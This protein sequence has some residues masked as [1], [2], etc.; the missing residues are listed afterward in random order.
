M[1]VDGKTKADSSEPPK[2]SPVVLLLGTLGDTTWRMFVP[3]V[4]LMSAGYYADK[5]FATFPWL[6]LLGLLAGTIISGFL[7]NNQLSKKV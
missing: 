1:S 6:F 4:G 2:T 7:I 3:T 5:E